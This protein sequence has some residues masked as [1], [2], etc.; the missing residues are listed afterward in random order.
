MERIIGSGGG[1]PVRYGPGHRIRTQVLIRALSSL[2]LVLAASL[3][4]LSL[5]KKA[6]SQST[7]TGA[8][9]GSVVDLQRRVIPGAQ[10]KLRAQSTGIERVGTTD[11]SGAFHFAGL[12]PGLYSVEANAGGFAAWRA[13]TLLVEVGRLT[14]VTA[15]LTVGGPQQ[16][17]VVKA[18]DTPGLD[19][20]SAAISTN[21]DVISLENLPSNGRRWSNFA[22]LTEG[23]TPDQNGY[24]LLSFRGI[25]VLLNNN[26]VDGADNNQAFFS[27]ERGR[28]RIG[29]ST[30]QVSV[31][32]FQVNTSNYSAE[33]GRAAG[34][35]VNTVT[36][37]GGNRFHGELFAFD[38]DNILGATNPF[39]T[40]TQR[41]TNGTFTSRTY[42][43]TDVR[44]QWGLGIGG[45]ILPG[46]MFW[47]MA[48]DQYLRV[49][50]GIA[51]ASSP[52][53]LFAPPSTKA[54]DT[55]ANRLGTT[56]AVAAADY[57][58]VLD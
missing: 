11:D 36:R 27:E 56:T 51:R 6:F 18:S 12:E 17:V 45:P 10:V 5:P 46:K 47:F 15:Q 14:E 39:T 32:E 20:T 7:T 53:R 54:I 58:S 43:P 33:Y 16:T 48:Y 19:T 9:S 41:Q 13:D 37:S 23:V 26:T 25:S 42:R 4:S 49:F 38:R 55:L 57:Q 24:G 30:T 1:L 31:Q 52:T 35:V 29:Y 3:L 8:A 40:L 28:T 21:V 22:L 34:G 2:G 50:P 44:K